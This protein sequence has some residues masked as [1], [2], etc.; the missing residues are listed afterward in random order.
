MSA[1]TPGPWFT[2]SLDGEVMAQP[3]GNRITLHV[4]V[5]GPNAKADARLIAASPEMLHCLA[6]ATGMLSA[7]MEILAGRAR[8]SS[9][10]AEEIRK[11]H[12]KCL[13]LLKRVAPGRTS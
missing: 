3:L 10:A 2:T 1:H 6:E 12:E 8:A 5:S 4:S 13:A 11:E 7:C 9:S